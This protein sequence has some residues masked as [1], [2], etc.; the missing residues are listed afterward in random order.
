MSH[1]PIDENIE[2]ERAGLQEAKLRGELAVLFGE[3]AQ[4]ACPI[5]L[6]AKVQYKDGRWGVVTRIGF[7]ADFLSILD[8]NAPIH[9]TVEGVRINKGASLG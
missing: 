6:G 5:R 3:K 2:A 7:F 4:R 8:E 1:E 9:W